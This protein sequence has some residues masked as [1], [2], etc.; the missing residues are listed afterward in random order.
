MHLVHRDAAMTSSRP[1]TSSTLPLAALQD[2][3]LALAVRSG[4]QL[5][6]GP[7]VLRAAAGTTGKCAGYCTSWTDN[8]TRTRGRGYRWL[9]RF[10][11]NPGDPPALEM[12]PWSPAEHNRA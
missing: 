7:G 5:G 9:P 8:P 11:W 4:E 12:L 3:G 2:H 6:L 10:A 1:A